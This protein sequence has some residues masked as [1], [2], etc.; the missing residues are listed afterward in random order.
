MYVVLEDDNV[1]CATEIVFPERTEMLRIIEDEVDAGSETYNFVWRTDNER[2]A[3]R[4]RAGEP[5]RWSLQWRGNLAQ[6]QR[7]FSEV[8]IDL[9]TEQA[10]VARLAYDEQDSTTGG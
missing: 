2:S 10:T 8:N 4:V 6:C 7:A 1:V 5:E 9:L 3:E